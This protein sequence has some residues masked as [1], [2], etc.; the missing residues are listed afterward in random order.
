MA[1]VAQ[2]APVT[3]S[4]NDNSDNEKG[5]ILY[6]IDEKDNITEVARV[7]SD[8]NSIDR[9]GVNS[10][11]RYFVVAYNVG[12]ESGRSN[13]LTIPDVPNVPTGFRIEI[14]IILVEES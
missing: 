5:F 3:F 9:E 11:E 1:S 14:K 6:L 2:A 10:G 13:I 7:G 8:V 12:G 4:W